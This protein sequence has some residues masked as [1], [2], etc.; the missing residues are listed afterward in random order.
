MDMA[1]K[2]NHASTITRIGK[3]PEYWYLDSSM[4][5]KSADN[6]P[7]PARGNT[8]NYP[9]SEQVEKDKLQ[10]WIQK[11]LFNIAKGVDH[12][13]IVKKPA[14]PVF[15]NAQG[16]NKQYYDILNNQYTITV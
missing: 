10:A 6:K 7:Y 11:H 15:N 3:D 16:A 2:M 14:Q 12:A 13:F 8:F 1:G 5:P 9:K 4:D